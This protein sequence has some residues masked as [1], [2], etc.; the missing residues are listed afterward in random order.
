MFGRGKVATTEFCCCL[1][2]RYPDEI[3]AEG[4]RKPEDS[5]APPQKRLTE[6]FQSVFLAR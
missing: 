4:E 5:A 1:L 3:E 2:W 6:T